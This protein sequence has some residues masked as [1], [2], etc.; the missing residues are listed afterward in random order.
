MEKTGEEEGIK[1]LHCK[2]GRGTEGRGL[3][4]KCHGD[5]RVRIQY[6][7][8]RREGQGIGLVVSKCLRG[9]KPT[10]YLPGTGEKIRV[11]GFRASKGWPLWHPED[12][13]KGLT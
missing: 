6:P 9:W 13:K 2:Q 8:L 11:L 1:C 3:C 4:R 5:R 10:K 12:A 7:T